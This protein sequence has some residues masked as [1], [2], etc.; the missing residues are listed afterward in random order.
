MKRV[1]DKTRHYAA[2]AQGQYGYS[3]RQVFEVEESDVNKAKA[4]YRG[5][6]YSDYQFRRGDIGKTITVY[7]DGTDWTCWSFN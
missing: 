6:K 5:H 3:F 4:N 1:T 2:N 7:T